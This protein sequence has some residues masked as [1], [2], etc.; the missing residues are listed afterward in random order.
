MFMLSPHSTH[1]MLDFRLTMDLWPSIKAVE[2]IADIFRWVYVDVVQVT[3]NIT[4]CPYG[5]EFA[6][7]DL[8]WQLWCVQ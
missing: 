5:N 1:P 3:R 4:C 7:F 2:G 8:V 6:V